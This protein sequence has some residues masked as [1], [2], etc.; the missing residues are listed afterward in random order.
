MNASFSG[1][2]KSHGQL[3][4]GIRQLIRP[5]ATFSPFEAETEIPPRLR[6]DSRGPSRST[7]RA[8]VSHG[9]KK[10]PFAATQALQ[11]LSSRTNTIKSPTN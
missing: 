8:F 9:E 6:A 7:R 1:N 11:V 3:A 2:R 10:T 4:R 5:A